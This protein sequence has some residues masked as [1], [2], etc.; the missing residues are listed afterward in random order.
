VVLAV[1][2]NEGVP[3][4]AL[5]IGVSR[6]SRAGKALAVVAF[7]VSL[8]AALYLATAES[9]GL[10]SGQSA[11]VQEDGTTVTSTW[12]D[13]PERNLDNERVMKIWAAVLVGVSLAALIAGFLGLTPL[14]WVVAVFLALI[15]FLG[16]WSIG[17]LFV[18]P[19][20]LFFLAALCLSLA[21]RAQRA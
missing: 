2:D 16:M 20:L 13:R 21:R 10:S 1:R 6:L 19:A 4:F 18:P 11:V 7:L 5:E 8:A 17:F 14:V 3:S 15:A 12:T 9:W